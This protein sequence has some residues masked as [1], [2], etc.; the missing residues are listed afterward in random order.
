MRSWQ[1]TLPHGV[2]VPVD[3]KIGLKSMNCSPG[4]Y[5]GELVIT[6]MAAP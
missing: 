4:R 5:D 1:P 6:V 3:L 2:D